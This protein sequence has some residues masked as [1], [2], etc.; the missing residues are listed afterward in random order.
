MH[1]NTDKKIT[2]A[3]YTDFGVLVPVC[4]AKKKGVLTAAE[5]VLADSIVTV[6]DRKSVV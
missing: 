4:E 2:D 5:V 1:Y 6:L 3:V